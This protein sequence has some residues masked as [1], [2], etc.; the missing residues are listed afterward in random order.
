MKSDLKLNRVAIFIDGSNLYHKLK[1]IN[2]QNTINFDYFGLCK[3]LSEN[4][5]LVF[6]AYYVGVIRVKPGDEKAKTMRSNQVILFNNLQKNKFTIKHGYLMESGGKYHEKGVDV[7][8]ATDLLIGAYEDLYDT[9]IL[10]SSDTDLIPSINKIRLLGKKIEY[11][12]FK[13]KPS[14]G[15]IKTVDSYKL[16]SKEELA[17]F[18]KL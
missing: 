13:H 10:I 7:H 3:F 18:I 4:N 6:Y 16:L 9:A 1:E 14:Y 15:L 17:N 5:Q 8:I 2:I 11:I 12:G